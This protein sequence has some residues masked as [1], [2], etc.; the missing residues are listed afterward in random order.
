MYDFGSRSVV[1]SLSYEGIR[2]AKRQNPA[3][4]V[5]YIVY[6]KLGDLARNDADFLSVSKG[7]ATRDLIASAQAQGKEIHVW[8]VN[9][10]REMSLMIDRGVDNIITDLPGE[11]VA[12]LEERSRLTVVE[13]FLLR[14]R[15]LLAS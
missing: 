15:A 14:V 3:L 4:E 8:T 11:L 6:Q 10:P 2:E 13:R 12:L 1:T 5:G 7:L 9:D